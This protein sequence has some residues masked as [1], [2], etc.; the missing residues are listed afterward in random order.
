[1]KTEIGQINLHL[2]AGFEARAQR[3]GRLIGESLARH[4]LPAG[5]LTQ[6]GVGPL[7]I[8]PRHSDRAIADNIAQSIGA[9]IGR[10]QD[11]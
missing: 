5:R 11:A 10:Q 9:A 7:H 1:M 2:P 3:I 6:V 8:D 4:D